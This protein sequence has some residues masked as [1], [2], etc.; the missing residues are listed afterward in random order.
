MREIVTAIICLSYVSGIYE[1]VVEGQVQQSETWRKELAWTER[2]SEE[3]V[4]EM[5]SSDQWKELVQNDEI[6]CSINR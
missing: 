2:K 5:V 6:K 4:R 1:I 3:Q